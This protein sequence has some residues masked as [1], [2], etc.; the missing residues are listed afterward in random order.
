[1]CYTS[2]NTGRPKGVVYTHRAL[3]LHSLA[4]ALPDVMGL[5]NAD[6]VCPVV[7]MFHC[8][9]VGPAVYHGDD[10]GEVRVSRART[11]TP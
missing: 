4:S 10:R 1:M 7:P 5:R 8:E 6:T 3:V 11:W 2:W 9:R